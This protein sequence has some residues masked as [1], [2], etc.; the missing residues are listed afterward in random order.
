MLGYDWLVSDQWLALS[1]VVNSRHPE[2][3]LFTFIETCD[4]AIWSSAELRHRSPD[5]SLL[6]TLLDNIMT[7]WSATITLAKNS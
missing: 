1:F 4:I 2:V 3:I 7:D 6:I 5:S